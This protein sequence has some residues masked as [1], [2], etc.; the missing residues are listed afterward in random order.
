MP[1]LY[2][3]A[4]DYA[5]ATI[6]PASDSL[7]YLN[8]GAVAR[9]ALAN[10][11]GTTPFAG[12]GETDIKTSAAWAT[13]IA[14]EDDD[15]VILLPLHEN[16]ELPQTTTNSRELASPVRRSIKKKG[17]PIT[18]NLKIPVTSLT[19]ADNLRKLSGLSQPYL[20]VSNL[21][22]YFLTEN[23]MIW[24][25]ASFKGIPIYNFMVDDP[26]QAE[27]T[28]LVPISFELEYGWSKGT[29]LVQAGFEVMKLA[30]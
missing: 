8:P 16:F 13:A 25:G 5:N 9:I 27:D 4:G 3:C 6:T 2:A 20:P 19:D 1:Q 23:D 30:A 28:L 18:V 11:A 17:N 29:T 14:D 15:R 26:M 12:T 7:C 22:V 24:Y 10:R 21:L